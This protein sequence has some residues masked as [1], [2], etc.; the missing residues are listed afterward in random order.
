MHFEV[1]KVNWISQKTECMPEKKSVAIYDLASRRTKT[2]GVI[3]PKLNSHF[4]TSALKGIQKV[5]ADKGYE[6]IITHSQESM[7]KEEASA[8]LLFD[9]QVDGVLASLT[10]GTKSTAHFTPFIDNRIP[11]VFFDRVDRAHSSGTVVIDNAGCGFLAT[12]HLIR[13]GCKRIAIITSDLGSDVYAQRYKGFRGAL[14]KYDIAFTNDLLINGDLGMDAARQVLRLK[15]LPDGLFITNDLAAAMCMHA[16][17]EAGIRIPEDIAIVGF[18]ND[19]VGRLI[20]PALTTVDYPG[21]E[22]G[23]TAALSLLDHLTGRRSCKPRTT[24]V[25]PSALIVRGSSLRSQAC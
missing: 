13:Q 10:I 11:V 6:I 14:E 4:I 22:V 23:R 5:I 17:K 15:P 18:N 9:R 3:V 1:K 8:Q 7:E 19:P 12:E 24:A 20:T 21:F 2:I 16:L 25:V